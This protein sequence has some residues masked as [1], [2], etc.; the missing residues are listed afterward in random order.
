VVY[1]CVSACVYA[2]LRACMWVCV[3][4][5]VPASRYVLTKY[6]LPHGRLLGHSFD[7]P[8]SLRVIIGSYTSSHS[9]T[10]NIRHISM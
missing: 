4:V 9:V 6:Y 7:G 10:H 5:W 2:C 3:R 1:V 8:I